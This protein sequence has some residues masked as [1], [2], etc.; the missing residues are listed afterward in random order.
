MREQHLH[1]LS[2][3]PRGE[4]GIGVGDVACHVADTRGWSAGSCAPARLGR[5]VP[6]DGSHR[7]RVRWHGAQHAVPIDQGTRLSRVT[8]P[9]ACQNFIVS[10][11][12]R[13]A[14]ETNGADSHQA[15]K[16][17]HKMRLVGMSRL[18]RLSRAERLDA[19][20]DR[21]AIDESLPLQGT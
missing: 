21:I 17:P 10:G 20:C 13:L 1:F 7:S 6:S 3:A 18:A 2:L 4:V 14:P 9:R 19:P 8:L 12:A 11:H 5:I 16:R 15:P